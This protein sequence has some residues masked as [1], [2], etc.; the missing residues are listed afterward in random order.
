MVLRARPSDSALSAHDRLYRSLRVQV[1][2]GELPPGHALTLRGLGAQFGV[3]S[4]L[5]EKRQRTLSRMLA[6]P[7]RPM[8]IVAGKTFVSLILGIVS[9]GIIVL[10]TALLL[11][12]RWGDPLAVAALIVALECCCRAA[13]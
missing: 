12:A 3:V 7:L 8:D 13:C 10:G 1:M 11:G 9:M 2:H 4:L 5:T 6:A